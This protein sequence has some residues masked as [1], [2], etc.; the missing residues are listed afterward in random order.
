MQHRPLV[1]RVALA[2]DVI[3][4]GEHRAR[5]QRAQVE[6]ADA[7]HPR[8]PPQPGHRVWEPEDAGAD[9]GGDEVPGGGR[10]AA[11]WVGEGCFGLGRVVLH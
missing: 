11:W 6:Q 3:A 9:D 1:A 2:L 7:R 8:H 4:V 10:P 5:P